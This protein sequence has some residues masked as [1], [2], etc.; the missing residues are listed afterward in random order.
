MCK[1]T[2]LFVAMG[3]AP[4]KVSLSRWY[5]SRLM[6]SERIDRQAH[7]IPKVFS[8]L[9]STR[10]QASYPRRN[11]ACNEP[12]LITSNLVT[13]TLTISPFARQI[14]LFARPVSTWARQREL[15]PRRPRTMR[16]CDR[17]ASFAGLRER[18]VGSVCC[19]PAPGRAG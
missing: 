15:G 2:R 14:P 11:W 17:Y 7:G 16:N 9:D 1:K 3:G 10:V 4:V 18:L 19:Q 5:I 12:G 6:V 8:V 13:L